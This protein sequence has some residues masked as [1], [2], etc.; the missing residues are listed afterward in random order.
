M[1]ADRPGCAV[2]LLLL[3]ALV[4]PAVVSDAPARASP[5]AAKPASTK[6]SKPKPSP[7]NVA[8]PKAKTPD[9][10]MPTAESVTGGRAAKTP[11]FTGKEAEATLQS[12]EMTPDGWVCRYRMPAVTLVGAAEGQ[13]P[14][15][16]V[17]TQPPVLL[18]PAT[19]A[20]S[21]AIAS[22]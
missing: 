12:C 19:A 14:P 10:K 15:V 5:V 22:Q 16:V 7:S 6:A 4:G 3:L 18:G 17:F 9:L 2:M 11:K 8:A 21:G 1:T 13:P 20:P